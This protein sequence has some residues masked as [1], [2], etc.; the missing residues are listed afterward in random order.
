MLT[1]LGYYFLAY[2]TVD[3][4]IAPLFNGFGFLVAYQA[5]SGRRWPENQN[6]WFSSKNLPLLPKKSLFPLTF[7]TIPPK[8]T[9]FWVFFL[10]I[11]SPFLAKRG[12][13]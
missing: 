10:S 7:F 8:N 11:K 2:L 9:H 6:T 12:F 5:L 3:R 13:L 4:H 1:P